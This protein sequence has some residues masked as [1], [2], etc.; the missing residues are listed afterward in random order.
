M[1]HGGQQLYNGLTQFGP[2]IRRPLPARKRGHGAGEA[3]ERG[4]EECAGVR[5]VGGASTLA[6]PPPR[7]EAPPR[8]SR[9]GRIPRQELRPPASWR[10]PTLHL[11]V[12]LLPAG[13]PHPMPAWGPCTCPS[14]HVHS[15]AM[16]HVHSHAT[17]PRNRRSSSSGA[18]RRVQRAHSHAPPAGE[19][20]TG[21]TALHAVAALLVRRPR[22][23]PRPRP[24]SSNTACIGL[25]APEGPGP[26]A[27]A[28]PPP[29]PLPVAA[30][31][32]RPTVLQPPP[33]PLRSRPLPRPPHP[34]PCA[35]QPVLQPSTSPCSPCSAVEGGGSA[36]E[37]T[38]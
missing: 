26:P 25:S 6:G 5:R 28:T 29:P 11:H 13:S 34:H 3:P 22:P 2:V 1:A 38:K 18:H 27:A 23:R 35:P 17:R 15:H 7:R 14:C 20:P 31:G 9:S 32:R 12:R 21:S 19:R 36:P 24:Q 10:R 30:G 33:P 8:P 4:L 16:C 37:A